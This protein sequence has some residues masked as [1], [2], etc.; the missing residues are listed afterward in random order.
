MF[1]MGSQQESEQAWQG[2]RY[3]CGTF[4]AAGASRGDSKPYNRYRR[5]DRQTF[6][7]LA[8]K[9]RGG[10]K[11]GRE[12]FAT[13]GIPRKVIPPVAKGSRPLRVCRCPTLE[14]NGEHFRPALLEWRLASSG[15]ATAVLT[16]LA[17]SL[18]GRSL[19]TQQGPPASGAE[20]KHA[21]IS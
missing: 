8:E 17:G 6:T 1:T 3:W 9:V 14:A 15:P 20:K 12:P 4:E 16:P 13:G 21:S 11:R 5:H 19:V 7:S 18:R 2:R 10:P